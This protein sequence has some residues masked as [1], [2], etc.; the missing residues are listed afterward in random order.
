ME[1]IIRA[2]QLNFTVA[3]VPITFVDRVFGASKLGNQEIVSY[4]QGLFKLFL[5]I[6]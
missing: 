2:R 3:E 4:L 6:E 5:Q 1:M